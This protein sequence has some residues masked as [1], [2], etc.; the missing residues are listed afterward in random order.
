MNFDSA[1]LATQD[2]LNK[3]IKEL[4]D[5]YNKAYDSLIETMPETDSES[6]IM[7]KRLET[8]KITQEEYQEW[9][10]EK[11]LL[12]QNQR[13]R[14]NNLSEI[15]TEADSQ[16]A[17]ITDENL[18]DVYRLNNNYTV[19]RI[20]D[21]YHIDINFLIFNEESVKLLV[22]ENPDLLPKTKTHDQRYNLRKINS[23]IALGIVNGESIDEISKR[24]AKIA[25]TNRN[26]AIR[27]ATTMVTTAQNAGRMNGYRRCQQ[28]GMTI[29]HRWL[30]AIDKHTR[31]SHMA[32]NGQIVD[33]GE[34]FS[35]GLEYPGDPSGNPA[36]VYNCRCC[37]VAV[38]DDI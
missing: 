10:A 24:V 23:A 34:K 12:G 16:C 1:Y 33:I 7:K 4:Q 19:S 5:I 3:V 31:D 13:K 18:P 21:H 22:Q 37:T 20:G 32:V 26:S 6:S 8:G 35:N 14:L 30:S 9:M 27:T 25:D 29:K 28:M 2:I 15:L 36:E 17:K 38:F 11:L